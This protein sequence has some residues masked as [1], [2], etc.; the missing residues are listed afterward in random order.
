MIERS[1]VDASAERGGRWAWAE[2]DLDAIAYNVAAL[3]AMAAPGVLCAV[4]KANGYG[5]G[6]V[7]AARAALEGGALWLAVALVSEG[8]EL[9]EAGITVPVLVLSEPPPDQFAA[10]AQWGLTP[11]VYTPVGIGAAA[12]AKVGNVHLKVDTGMHRVGATPADT[13]SLMAMI[14]S[15]EGIALGGVF[16]HLACADA[17]N[18]SVSMAQLAL[19]ADVAPAVSF[20]HVANSAGL[21]NGLSHDMA[22]ARAGIAIY[23]IAPAPN[24]VEADVDLRPALSLKARVSLVKRVPAGSAVSYGHRYRTESETTLATVPIGYADGVPR[25]LGSAGGRVLIGGSPHPIA[26]VVTMDQLVVDVGNLDVAVG[27][28]VVLI[29]SQGTANIDAYDWAQRLDTIAY[30]I[31]CGISSRVPRVYFG[32]MYNSTIPEVA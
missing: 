19:F 11:T 1:G 32:A 15:S 28:E 21:I 24:M 5:H 27:D 22:M 20:R 16:T 10:C 30:E 7:P 31:V 4:V 26:G 6:A 29:G 23:G 14:D 3:G 2:I 9:R 25:R 12:A 8:V 13:G 17:D 18:Q